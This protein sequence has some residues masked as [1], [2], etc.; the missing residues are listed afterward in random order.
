MPFRNARATHPAAMGS[1]YTRVPGA[2]AWAWQMKLGITGAEGLIAWHLRAYLHMRGGCEVRLANRAVFSDVN[3]LHAFLDGL[4][5]VVH[6]AGANRGDESVVE[7]TNV[8]L[9]VRLIEA[10][11]HVLT[12]PRLVFANSTH[13]DRDTGYGRGKRTAAALLAGWADR[14][15]VPF[16]NLIF[17]HV[18]GEF[19]RPFYNSV[20][21]TFCNQLAR[22]EQPRI[23]VDNR[24]ELLHAQDAAERIVRAIEDPEGRDIRVDG[25]PIMVSELLDRL[26]RMAIRYAG[27]VVP[28]LTQPLHMRLFNVLRSYLFP[29]HYPVTLMVRTD[30][31][32]ALFETVKSDSGGQTFL[33]TTRPG[34]TRGNHFH[35]RKVERFLVVS[36]DAEIRLRR[37]FTDT[38]EVFRVS[39]TAPCYVD[40]PTFH[41]HS[42]TNSGE[43]DLTTLFWSNEIF[44]P[45]DSDTYAEPVEQ[46]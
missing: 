20:V 36:G 44:D 12:R 30:N 1:P 25:A 32:G 10:L 17:P 24:I 18:F 21:A 23:D 33:S 11:E 39:G 16:Q 5:A 22:H 26:A 46:A 7:S 43:H 27:Q 37:L 40:M 6:L 41:T 19:Q 14:S 9:A 45:A 15:G 8:E 13:H 29:T 42:I 4:D 3:R 2:S 38:I 35:S 34:V 31:R 28:D